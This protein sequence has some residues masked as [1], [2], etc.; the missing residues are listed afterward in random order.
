MGRP[1]RNVGPGEREPAGA[2]TFEPSDATQQRRLSA[3][4]RAEKH[5]VLPVG[6]GEGDRPQHRG[7]SPGR[8]ERIHFEEGLRARHTSTSE[9]DQAEDRETEQEEQAGRRVH[10]RG[11]IPGVREVVERDRKGRE[12]RSD[13]EV[14]RGELAEAEGEGEQPGGHE[15]VPDPRKVG[16]EERSPTGRAQ[17]PSDLALLARESRE[18]DLEALQ[19][20]GEGER[21][22]A[23]D[24]ERP[25]GRFPAKERPPELGEGEGEDDRRE[26]EGNE[27][28]QTEPLGSPRTSRYRVA[29][30][31]PENERDPGGDGGEKQRVPDRPERGD[32]ELLGGRRGEQGGPRGPGAPS[33]D[34][35]ERAV[36]H[37]PQQPEYGGEH[38]CGFPG[39]SEGDRTSTTDRARRG[40]AVPAGGAESSHREE[41][42]GGREQKQRHHRRGK[43]PGR[44]RL[45][46]EGVE[47]PD[48]RL[49]G[50]AARSAE[51]QR[52]GERERR[53]Q[54][55][56]ET[57]GDHSGPG[58]WSPDVEIGASGRT[59][60]RGDGLFEFREAP[61]AAGGGE[62]HHDRDVEEEVRH[63]DRRQAAP[64]DRQGGDD[65]G[66]QAG[67][68][69]Q[70]QHPEDDHEARQK[71]GDE[72]KRSDGGSTL[73]VVPSEEDPRGIPQR[74]RESGRQAPL[75]QR[76][77]DGA[78]VVR[79]GEDPRYAGRSPRGR[80]RVDEE[81]RDRQ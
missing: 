26:E 46:S 50:V 1:V 38:D 48:L 59:A 70:V 30:D 47:E 6:H 36:E 49:D 71:E 3:P 42:R 21:R 7:R 68:P 25:D 64:E 23:D 35:D 5:E 53:E 24:H 79:G 61:L 19:R 18:R 76:V 22:L 28:Q 56:Q 69:E 12:H 16:V 4:V 74:D 60:E 33:S 20:E 52:W 55:R 75:H 32:P 57:A 27:E 9:H 14:R 8:R 54:E 10:D 39:E 63:D 80:D 44:R 37:R 51:E 65:G 17:R 77:L 13:Q 67:G 72:Q 11:Q 73:P 45:E 2:R 62:Q 29:G 34:R 15:T 78:H 31:D 43:N 66:D 58:R 81:D 41:I 40:A